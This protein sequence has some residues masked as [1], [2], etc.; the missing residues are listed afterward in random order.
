VPPVPLPCTTAYWPYWALQ[1]LVGLS[2]VEGM[3]DG[4]AGLGVGA[5]AAL[6]EAGQWAAR[7]DVENC[8]APYCQRLP[9][10]AK[11][12]KAQ[13]GETRLRH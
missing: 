7:A 2:F 1:K 4:V 12:A 3:R 11:R 13:H 5:E 10:R 6:A 9:S 8:W